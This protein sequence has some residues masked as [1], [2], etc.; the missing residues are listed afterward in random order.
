MAQRY[1]K[2][3]FWFHQVPNEPENGLIN[4]SNSASFMKSGFHFA[5][6]FLVYSYARDVAGSL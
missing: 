1:G 3:R 4:E 2:T 5:N 6:F